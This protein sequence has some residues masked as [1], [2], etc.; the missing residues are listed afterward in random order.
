MVVLMAGVP[1]AEAQLS[2]DWMIT[3]VANTPGVGGTYWRTD[4]SL[5][6]P[7]E[8][9]LPVI[10]QFLPSGV[11]NW[12]AD[13]F[14]IEL[15]PWETFNLWDVLGTDWFNFRG[16]GAMLVYAD[17]ALA[18]N[19]I[20]DCHFLATS[21]TYT[22]TPDGPYGEYGQTISG[23]DVWQAVNWDT[24]G[25]AAGVLNDGAG[26]RSNVGVSSWSRDWTLVRLD[27][28]D[29]DGVILATHEFDVPPF[30][31][32]Q[33][34]LDTAVEGGG[35]VFYVVDGPSDARVFPYASVVDQT[36]GDPSYQG[37]LASVVGVTAAKS[38]EPSATRPSHPDLAT[39][40]VA[41][42]AAARICGMR[43]PR[44]E[45]VQDGAVN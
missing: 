32:V 40:R 30:S 42:R 41:A 3:A 10:I 29:G 43:D 22:V 18:C 13:Y 9:N 23:V 5:H 6:N 33:E 35:L 1:A 14:W 4:L 34:R 37:A 11:D 45:S 27:V 2:A 36:T 28:Q 31:H 20:E 19:P 12:Q 44:S 21:R 7:H 39:R 26:F 16:T 8:F 25:Y 38:A 15:Y 24:Y 17:T